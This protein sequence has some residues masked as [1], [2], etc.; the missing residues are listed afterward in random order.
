MRATL[1]ASDL[2]STRGRVDVLR[3]L[4][5]VQIPMTAAEVARRT[6]MTHPAVSSVLGV[7]ADYG[8]ADSAPAGRGHVYWLNRDNVYVKS[9]VDPVF[10]AE[11]TAPDVLLE[12]IRSEFED[13]TVSV[14]LFG[15]YAR[16]DQT[17]DSDIDVI[18]VA[19]NAGVKREIEGSMVA[20]QTAFR[21][22]F[23]ATLSA[24]VYDP[25]EAAAL[26][27]RAPDLHQSVVRDGVRVCGLDVT[28]WG[29]LGT[30]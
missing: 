7:L 4:W 3:A 6:R 1:T 8:V 20:S 19:H 30:E 24:I 25:S 15:S 26:P 17:P 13:R 2:F 11:Q 23:G 9:L 29:A 5:G 21:R 18:A 12:A 14:V 16:G 10:L 27:E 22:A 28:E